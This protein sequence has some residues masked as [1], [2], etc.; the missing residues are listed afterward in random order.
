MKLKITRI[1]SFDLSRADEIPEDDLICELRDSFW[2]DKNRG[3]VSAAKGWAHF[4]SYYASQRPK[5]L[6]EHVSH[7]DGLVQIAERN[8]PLAEDLLQRAARAAPWKPV[9]RYR[10][11]QL[12]EDLLII[13]EYRFKFLEAYDLLGKIRGMYNQLGT[14]PTMRFL[15]R[16]SRLCRRLDKFEDNRRYTEM[17]EAN[18]PDHP[19]TRNMATYLAWE[20]YILSHKD[21]P[22]RDECL[23]KMRLLLEAERKRVDEED[24]PDSS[25][26]NNAGVLEYIRKDYKKSIKYLKE[27]VELN[28]SSALAYFNLGLA[29]F[30]SG[31]YAAARRS[32]EKARD[33][34]RGDNYPGGMR[35]AQLFKDISIMRGS[36]EVPEEET[37]REFLN[38]IFEFCDAIDNSE[39]FFIERFVAESEVHDELLRD[40]SDVAL[41]NEL[42]VLR[43]WHSRYLP[44]LEPR[45][46]V[47]GGYFL[48]SG[49]WGIAIDPGPNFVSQLVSH[50]LPIMGVDLIVV[51]SSTMGHCH[52]LE[53][54]LHFLKAV[55]GLRESSRR[56]PYSIDPFLKARIPPD[57]KR[58]DLIMTKEAL[59]KFSFQ[60]ENTY[61]NVIRNLKILDVDQEPFAWSP[62]A[63]GVSQEILRVQ[64]VKNRVV[65][66][67]YGDQPVGVV[68]D[69][70]RPDEST[71]KI[72]YTSDTMWT[73]Q[74]ER[75]PDRVDLLLA[76]LGPIRALEFRAEGSRDSKL[77]PEHLGLY[78][79]FRLI[80]HKRPRLVLLADLGQE[81]LRLR[82]KV[83]QVFNGRFWESRD[84]G[85]RTKTVSSEVGMRIRLEDLAVRP[86][87]LDEFVAFAEIGER[88]DV[89]KTK[90]M[91]R[92]PADL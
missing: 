41:Q 66:P 54:L 79:L 92:Q 68:L 91:Y 22:Y 77:N 20:D 26:L 42:L 11:V 88:F 2:Y 10:H 12:F 62:E 15:I 8:Y 73:N 56:E 50:R 35:N 47:G 5:A 69:L 55:N 87:G 28:E 81:L 3:D 80:M 83:T 16:A 48:K 30:R 51:T 71:I 57:R 39:N 38:F 61:K 67:W 13:L 90:H 65:S 33:L 44:P 78:G 46:P 85:N 76:H 19:L 18:A 14:P 49:G 9:F 17:A 23:E 84:R 7:F 25:V 89:R 1:R 40:R 27:T 29:E 36:Q 6:S 74:L 82:S 70:K 75:C 43:G 63:D 72:W 64:P 24:L 4:G 53:K 86:R 32:F 58:V 21:D 31:D 45:R 60:I 59:S 37:E 52:D 34:Y